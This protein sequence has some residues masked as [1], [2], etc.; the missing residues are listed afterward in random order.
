M[1]PQ[2]KTLVWKRLKGETQCFC[3]LRK[4]Q[5]KVKHSETVPIE[6]DPK[7]KVIPVPATLGRKRKA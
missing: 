7:G 4:S 5:E 1:G 2:R 3:S 6:V